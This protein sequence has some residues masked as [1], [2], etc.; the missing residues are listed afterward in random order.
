MPLP[1]YKIQHV[2]NKDNE[3]IKMQSLSLWRLYNDL[4]RRSLDELQ[5]MKKKK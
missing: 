2:T 3:K 1:Y 4:R 5:N